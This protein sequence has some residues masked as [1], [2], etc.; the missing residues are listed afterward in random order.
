[1]SPLHQ[2]QSRSRREHE[3]VSE[4]QEGQVVNRTCTKCGQSKPPRAFHRGRHSWCAAC[5]NAHNR[6]WRARTKARLA[7]VREQNKNIPAIDNVLHRPRLFYGGNL[8]MV[9][10]KI[11]GQL[12]PVFEQLRELSFDFRR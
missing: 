9:N 5:I 4:W 7:L 12:L 10:Q 3:A 1:M 2:A 8:A 6:A 11:V